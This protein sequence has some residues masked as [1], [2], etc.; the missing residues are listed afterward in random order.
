MCSSFQQGEA[1]N[2]DIKMCLSSL[3]GHHTYPRT[4]RMTSP[5]KGTCFAKSPFWRKVLEKR[6]HPG[7][8]TVLKSASSHC[9]TE[10][11]T[12][13]DTHTGTSQ[14][15]GAMESKNPCQFFVQETELFAT[16]SHPIMTTTIQLGELS[17]SHTK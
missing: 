15:A 6:Q 9:D 3:K 17:L 12:H 13:G 2:N 5:L 7:L 1:Q 11:F 8:T 16:N 4:G 10:P 14:E